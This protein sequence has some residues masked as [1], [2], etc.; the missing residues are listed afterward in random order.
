ML[1]YEKPELLLFSG[2]FSSLGLK[3]EIDIMVQYIDKFRRLADKFVFVPGNHDIYIDSSYFFERFGEKDNISIDYDN[4]FFRV[5]SFNSSKPN[6]KILDSNGMVDPKIL[7]ELEN[8]L[9]ND[10]DK[11]T[12]LLT[13]YPIW[14]DKGEI[15]GYSRR[16]LNYRKIVDILEGKRNVFYLHG[17]IHRNYM[18]NYKNIYT[19]CS[20]SLTYGGKESA[21]LYE[22][23][24]QKISLFPII[25]DGKRYSVERKRKKIFDV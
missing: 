11:I 7:S 24:P 17:H 18:F 15:P 14:N 23:E 22:I 2:D 16:L 25:Y 13:H 5:V 21:N 12:F 8:V 1:E 19:F 20:G 6:P 4:G 10:E 3:C 9:S